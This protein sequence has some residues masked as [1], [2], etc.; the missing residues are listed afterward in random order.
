MTT[1][2]AC[3]AT[4]TPAHPGT[5]PGPDRP[6]LEVR[7]LRVEFTQYERGLRRRTVTGVERMSLDVRAGEVVALVGA[8]GAGKSLLGHA[9]L[10]LLPPNGREQG[11]ISWCGTPVDAAARRRLAGREIALLPQSLSHLD[12]AATAGAQLRRAARL[13]GADRASARRYVAEA[14]AA[15]GLGPEVAR[16]YPHQLSGGMGRRVLTAMAL[17]GQPRV[18]VADE[19]TPGLGPAEVRTVLGR[20]RSLADEG[21]GVLLITHELVGALGVADRVVVVDRGRTVAEEQ[22]RDFSGS[23]AGLGNPY[24]RALWRALPANGFQVTTDRAAQVGPVQT[25]ERA[26]C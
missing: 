9:V 14:L 6:L 18:V 20:L 11:T 4:R 5:G 12:P 16:R 19:P 21:R 13:A 22:V 2:S 24:S 17:A 1:D 23:G 8:S 10:G 7:D 26:A 3:L 25:P 15:Q